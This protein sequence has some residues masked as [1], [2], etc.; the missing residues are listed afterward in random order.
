MSNEVTSLP[1]DE[2]QI[3]RA[4]AEELAVKY[5]QYSREIVFQKL[6][7]YTPNRVTGGLEQA[8][9]YQ[10]FGNGKPTQNLADRDGFRSKK[11]TNLETLSNSVLAQA[12]YKM[13]YEAAKRKIR[14]E[15]L[16]EE[17]R[18]LGLVVREPEG[19]QS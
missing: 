15:Q 5:P 4:L 3:F 19:G 10:A 12:Q 2:A 7:E 1:A 14:R 17:A 13:D 8:I 11:V 9:K 18:E 6:Y 16:V